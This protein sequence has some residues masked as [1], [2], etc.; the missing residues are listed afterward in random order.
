MWCVMGWVLS[1]VCCDVV[2]MGRVL[3]CVILLQESLKQFTEFA[4]MVETQAVASMKEDI[5]YGDIP[6]E[7]KGQN[8]QP[9]SYNATPLFSLFHCPTISPSFLPSSVSLSLPPFH[10]YMYMY[11]QTLSWI[12]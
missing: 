7:F 9:L 11:I 8:T 3:S 2:C 6:D 1:C 5:T 4:Q 12:P 10:L